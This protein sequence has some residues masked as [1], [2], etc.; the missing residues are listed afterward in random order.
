MAGLFGVFH[1][2][3][4]AEEGV[5]RFGGKEGKEI[6]GKTLLKLKGL[7][8]LLDIGLTAWPTAKRPRWIMCG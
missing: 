3:G 6:F 1:G 4:V 7:L 2:D 5:V 8:N